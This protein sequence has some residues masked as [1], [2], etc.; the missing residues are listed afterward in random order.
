MLS[1]PT[2]TGDVLDRLSILE[3]KVDR[4]PVEKSEKAR[5]HLDVLRAIAGPLVSD[6][7]L[8][9]LRTV[10][11]A[12]WDTK[13]S[14]HEHLHRPESPDFYLA[15]ANVAFL[16]DRRALLKSKADDLFSSSDGNG[17]YS[18]DD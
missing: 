13:T 15:A 2:T 17:V 9:E 3:L 4:L 8:E 14:I 12:L 10:N 6:P 5:R 16:N 1:V 18:S 11:M 7:L